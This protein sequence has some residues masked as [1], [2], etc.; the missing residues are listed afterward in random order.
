MGKIRYLIYGSI[1]VGLFALIHWVFPREWSSWLQRAD[2]FFTGPPFGFR[3]IYVMGCFFFFVFTFLFGINFLASF[4]GA[5]YPK[6]S[7]DYTPPITVLMPAINEEKNI[8]NTLAS[9]SQATYPKD[10]LEMVVIASG[11]T[12]RT[13]EICREYEDRLNIKILTDPLP[14]KGKPAALNYGLKHSSH[15]IITVYDADTQLYENTLKNLVRHLYDPAVA[16]T[17]GPV[18]PRNWAD[19][20][21]TKGIA[22]EYTYISGTGLYHEVRD[23][24]GRSLWLLGRNY[25]I[26]KSIIEEFGGWNEDALTEDLHLSAQLSSAKKKIKFAPH[27]LINEKVPN[28]KEAFLHQ[29]RRWVG[30]YSQSLSSAMELDTRT[31][32]LRNFAMMHYG[33]TLDFSIGAIIPALIFGLIGDFY[34]MLIVIITA[35]F[36]LGTYIMGVRK[37]GGG[38]YRLLLYFPITIY[39][40]ITMFRQQFNDNEELEWEKTT[41]D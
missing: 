13:A 6:G 4:G 9:F 32:I 24:L 20:K 27:A 12:D 38:K 37:Y 39:I 11:S 22:L 34:L 40:D 41:M 15:D 21:L 33:H 10:N 26:R 19:N 36:A 30:G 7:E 16:A 1:I 8:G 5:N 17:S 25:A 3:V 2:L 18:T 23:R 29:R 31:V 14:K 28:T 35:I